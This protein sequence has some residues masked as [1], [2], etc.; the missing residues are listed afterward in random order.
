MTI[1]FIYR[2]QNQGTQFRP[3]IRL[4]PSGQFG[5]TQH[6]NQNPA[7]LPH[8]TARG[9]QSPNTLPN[10]QR[11]RPPYNP[12]QNY[13]VAPTSP[14]SA[15][16]GYSRIGEIDHSRNL[17]VRSLNSH[18]Q[19]QQQNFHS[20][21]EAQQQQQTLQ[22]ADSKVEQSSTISPPEFFI[23]GSGIPDSNASVDLKERTV[24]DEPRQKTAQT[25]QKEKSDKAQDLEAYCMC[26][27]TFVCPFPF[28]VHTQT[29]TH[30]PPQIFYSQV[31]AKVQL[32]AIC[33]EFYRAHFRSAKVTT[34]KQPKSRFLRQPSE[35]S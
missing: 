32:A 30:I 34:F 23:F 21:P 3:P 15:Q 22:G 6:G 31:L 12:P 18:S 13:H 9:W 10:Q 17:P 11:Y 2:H 26:P 7:P 25:T 28:T 5:H 14:A 35:R 29:P 24:T 16:T 4:G 27:I 20:R 8:Q 19:N 1:L 33:V